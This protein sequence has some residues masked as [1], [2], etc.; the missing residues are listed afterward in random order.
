[1]VVLLSLCAALS[2]RTVAEQYPSGAAG[3]LQLA[4]QIGETAPQGAAVLIVVRDTGE[5]AAFASAAIA[6]LQPGHFHIVSVVRGQP[7]DVRRAI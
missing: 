5:D 4:R 1:M 2:V 6:G 3:G 7:A